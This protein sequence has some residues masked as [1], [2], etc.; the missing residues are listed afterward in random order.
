MDVCNTE[1]SSKHVVIQEDITVWPEV[2]SNV[3]VLYCGG[4]KPQL[5]KVIEYHIL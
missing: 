1:Q 5:L 2:Y 3:L 4:D